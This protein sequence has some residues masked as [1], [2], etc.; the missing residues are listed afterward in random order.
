MPDHILEVVVDTS[1]SPNARLR[2]VPLTTVRLA[3]DFWSPR[4]G[5]SRAV[6]LPTQYQLLEET[7][8][9]DSFRAAVGKEPA[10][11]GRPGLDR[12]VRSGA[13]YKK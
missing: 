10:E 4:L 12:F 7:G 13:Y 6:T 5:T 9:I 1:A 3:D 11:Y 8:R 2:P